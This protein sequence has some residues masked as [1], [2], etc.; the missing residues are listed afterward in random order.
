MVLHLLVLL[1]D[2]DN[3]QVG[4]L[5]E[6]GNP[7]LL[8]DIVPV[9]EVGKSAVSLTVAVYIFDVKSACVDGFGKTVVLV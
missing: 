2:F 4:G 1:L 9:G 7:T 6:P 3:A 5:N 8:Q